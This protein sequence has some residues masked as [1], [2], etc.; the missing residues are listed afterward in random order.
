[1]ILYSLVVHY[2]GLQQKLILCECNIRQQSKI[3]LGGPQGRSGRFVEKKNLL[4]PAQNKTILTGS[5]R[6]LLI[7]LTSVPESFL[8]TQKKTRRCFSLISRLR[9]NSLQLDP[10]HNKEANTSTSGCGT[11]FEV[12]IV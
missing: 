9:P 3:K 6:S 1:M 2:L 7:L 4:F 5:A 8:E 12:V 10:P 11:Y